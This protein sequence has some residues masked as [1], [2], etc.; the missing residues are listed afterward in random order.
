VT[1]TTQE[2]HR[3]LE[4]AVVNLQWLTIDPDKRN[5]YSLA[6]DVLTNVPMVPDADRPEDAGIRSVGDWSDPTGDEATQRVA[7]LEELTFAASQ[8]T[9]TAGW[10]ITAATLALGRPAPLRNPQDLVEAMACIRWLLTIPH[11]VTNAVDALSDSPADAELAR[12]IDANV[13]FVDR[14]VAETVKLT[15]RA[16]RGAVMEDRPPPERIGKKPDGCRS[17]ARANHW[18][19]P[20]PG[21]TLCAACLRFQKTYKCWPT[22]ATV[23]RWHRTGKRS[24]VFDRD[25]N[26][27][28]DA[29][30]VR[31]RRAVPG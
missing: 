7:R 17:C 28:R 30:R 9:G 25:V 14:Q 8:V 1:L 23:D 16:L 19:P 22:P 20:A 11:T 6:V 13:A 31:G 15:T 4:Q 24:Q 26:E 10:L 27:A 5:R 12:E 2:R 29:R 3:H 21:K 18:S